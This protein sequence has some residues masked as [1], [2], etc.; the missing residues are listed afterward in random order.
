[1][2]FKW[3]LLV[4]SFVCRLPIHSTTCSFGAFFSF[5]VI[6]FIHFFKKKFHIPFFTAACQKRHYKH[7]EIHVGKQIF[8]I[9]LI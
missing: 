5:V 1:M 7:F 8:G 6:Y 3:N 2:F 4:V 9:K